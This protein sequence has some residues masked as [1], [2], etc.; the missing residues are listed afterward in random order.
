MKSFK[1]ENR[2]WLHGYFQNILVYYVL[3]NFKKQFLVFVVQAQ[4]Y[5]TEKKLLKSRPT[6]SQKRGVTK[7]FIQIF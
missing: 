2:V 5:T 4:C 6:L 3:F 7:N 1:T